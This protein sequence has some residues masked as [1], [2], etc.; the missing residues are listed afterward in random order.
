MWENNQK[1]NGTEQN[2]KQTSHFIHYSDSF[3]KEVYMKDAEF[4]DS[5]QESQA[6]GFIGVWDAF[7]M[8]EIHEI[9]RV[10]SIS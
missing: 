10:S 1:K 3:W 5:T 9:I 4:T 8:Q 7:R 2:K 6:Y